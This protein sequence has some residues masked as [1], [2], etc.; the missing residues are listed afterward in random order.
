MLTDAEAG[1]R[2]QQNPTLKVTQM[3]PTPE[4]RASE[5]DSNVVLAIVKGNASLTEALNADLQQLLTDGKIT[6][7]L[8]SNG[9]DPGLAGP[10]RN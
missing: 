2:A 1:H 4:V 7:I 10:A 6:S 3:Q 9:M 8:E 5:A